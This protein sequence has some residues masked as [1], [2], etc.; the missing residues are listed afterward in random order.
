MPGLLQSAK[1]RSPGRVDQ[2][3]G[4]DDM[5]C[6][7]ISEGTRAAAVRTLLHGD[8]ARQKNRKPSRL[9]WKDAA[10]VPAQQEGEMTMQRY[11]I[12][13]LPDGEAEY[14]RCN[15]RGTLSF[16]VLQDLVGGPIETIPTMLSDGWA[17]EDGARVV[18][19]VNEEGRLLGLP[20]NEDA[21]L[22][23]AFSVGPI[24]GAALI[25]AAQEDRLIGLRPDAAKRIMVEWLRGNK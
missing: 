13:V 1:R 23:A 20:H 8:F 12:R 11:V 22:M 15:S 19:I 7:T 16:R 3:R 17:R 4:Y 14:I 2:V 21:S 5:R 18:M 6:I 25:M 10:V 9:E 24:V